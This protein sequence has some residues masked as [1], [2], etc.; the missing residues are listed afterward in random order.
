MINKIREIKNEMRKILKGFFVV[1]IFTDQR[2]RINFIGK[3][4]TKLFIKIL[5]I[6]IGK[7]MIFLHPSKQKNINNMI[8]DPNRVEKNFSL[9]VAG[10]SIIKKIYKTKEKM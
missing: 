9:P 3:A 2:D 4:I 8:G 1:K 6:I 10:A 5:T 7:R